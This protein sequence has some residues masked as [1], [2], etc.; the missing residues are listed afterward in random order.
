MWDPKIVLVEVI[1]RGDQFIHT[2]ISILSA[3]ISFHCTY[4]YAF[5]S[6][7]ERESLWPVLLAISDSMQGPWVLLGDFNTCLRYDERRKAGN[8][9]DIDISKLEAFTNYGGLSD[10]R[11][12][13]IFLTWCNKQ[14]GEQIQYTKLDRIIV[15]GDWLR[16]FSWPDA[17]FL[18]AGISDHSLGIL[19]IADHEHRSS[20]F[21]YCNFWATNPQFESLVKEAWSANIEGVPMYGVAQKLKVVKQKLKNL[22]KSKYNKLDDKIKSAREQLTNIQLK[23]NEDPT[24]LQWQIMEQQQYKEFSTLAKA[25]AS[26]YQQKVKAEWL[27]DMDGN[28]TYFHAKLQ[29]RHSATRIKRIMIFEGEIIESEEEVAQQFIAF[30]EEL[31]GTANSEISHLRPEVIIQRGPVLDQNQV[32]ALYTEVTNEEIK[33]ALFSIFSNKAPVSDGFGACFFKSAWDI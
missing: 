32:V 10:L 24:N 3:W 31:Y 9:V 18:H 25:K 12:S 1:E 26:L 13:G 7:R 29:E 17:H 21:R 2:K 11:F 33:S 23:V 6:Q 4:G 14:E 15:N 20:P 22:H 19:H 5:N 27:M 16:D 28:I 30:Y 8:I